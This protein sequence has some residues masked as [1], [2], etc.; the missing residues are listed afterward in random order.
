MS[1]QRRYLIQPLGN[2][3]LIAAHAQGHH[4][5][6]PCKWCLPSQESSAAE[7]PQAR[8]TSGKHNKLDG[9]TRQN[10]KPNPTALKSPPAFV[11]TTD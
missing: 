8:N 4:D 2:T 11:A 7:Q 3:R 5:R 9:G 6:S 1:K 10:V